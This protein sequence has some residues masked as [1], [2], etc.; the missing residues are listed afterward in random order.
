MRDTGRIRLDELKQI[1]EI[2]EF[3]EED[4]AKIGAII[5]AIAQIE[6]DFEGIGKTGDGS[7]P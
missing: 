4:R 1:H 7:K 2:D 5:K 6:A 3:S